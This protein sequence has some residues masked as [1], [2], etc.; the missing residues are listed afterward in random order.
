M[1]KNTAIS[2]LINGIFKE[3]PVFFLLLGLCPALAVTTDAYLAVIM[4]LTT[5][6]VLI[7]SSLCISRADAK[8]PDQ[9]RFLSHITIIAFFVTLAELLISAFMPA[10]AVALGI[11]LPL[12]AVNCLIMQRIQTYAVKNNALMS[13]LDA[14]GMGMG[15]TLA[16]FLVGA[17]REILGSGSLFGLRIMPEAYEKAEIFILAP[18]AFFVLA[19]LV[20]IYNRLR[21]M[22]ADK[23]METVEKAIVLEQVI[24]NKEVV[25]GD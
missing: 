12:I 16:L 24:E 6:L 17:A 18:G 22:S 21:R 10:V 2:R 15:F 25:A 1:S 14:C 13:F 3:N 7:L 23:P 11:Y 19:F 20:A 4:G 8:I 9:I 5:M